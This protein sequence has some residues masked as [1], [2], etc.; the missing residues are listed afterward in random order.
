MYE[1]LKKRKNRLEKKKAEKLIETI[2]KTEKSSYIIQIFL[3]ILKNK[4]LCDIW[5]HSCNLRSMKNTD[6][7]VLLLVKLQAEACNFTKSNIPPW[8]FFM[9]FKLCT[10]S[11]SAPQIKIL[12]IWSRRPDSK[13]DAFPRLKKCAVLL[14]AIFFQDKDTCYP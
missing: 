14:S 1:R 6:V 4:V 12:L 8:L 3:K 13:L 10:K 2:L 5:Y 9:F 11:R 7:G